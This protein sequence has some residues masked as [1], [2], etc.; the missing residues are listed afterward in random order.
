MESNPSHTNANLSITLEELDNLGDIERESILP[1]INQVTLS[2]LSKKDNIND[3]MIEKSPT[4]KFNEVDKSIKTQFWKLLSSQEKSVIPSE[5]IEASN[6]MK[7]DLSVETNINNEARKLETLIKKL[8]ISIGVTVEKI[9]VNIG[10][11]KSSCYEQ[12]QGFC[13][14]TEK[15]TAK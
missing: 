7:G 13:Y 3:P 10:K 8:T 9:D 2:I 11:N 6:K 15:E 5:M 14:E 4:T 1:M 12:T